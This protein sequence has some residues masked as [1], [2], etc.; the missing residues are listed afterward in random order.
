LKLL[1][2][3]GRSFDY[4]SFAGSKRFAHMIRQSYR[5]RRI[6]FSQ[7]LLCSF[8]S[9]ADGFRWKESDQL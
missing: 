4:Q 7:F 2:Q 3:L 6:H 8:Q 5:E 9:R 1:K